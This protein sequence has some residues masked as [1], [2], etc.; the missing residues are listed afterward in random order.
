MCRTS[1]T[2]GEFACSCPV[3]ICNSKLCDAISRCSLTAKPPPES[4]WDRSTEATWW[5]SAVT[6]TA[7]KMISCKQNCH[8]ITST[9]ACCVFAIELVFDATMNRRSSAKF[10]FQNCLSYYRRIVLHVSTGCHLK[11]RS[12]FNNSCYLF[13]RLAHCN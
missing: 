3:A 2:T 6:V 11:F 9:H 5:A 7:A 13:D 8:L 10:F 1:P 4:V 12:Y